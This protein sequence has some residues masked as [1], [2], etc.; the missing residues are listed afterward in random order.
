[1]KAFSAVGATLGAVGVLLS[2]AVLDKLAPTHLF[3]V[4]VVGLVFALLGE[5]VIPALRG[6]EKPDDQGDQQP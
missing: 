3:W 1:M 4:L 5:S 6:K 2:P